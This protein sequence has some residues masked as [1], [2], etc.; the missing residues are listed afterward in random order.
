[1][2]SHCTPPLAR[3]LARQGGVSLIE[4]MI[5]MTIGLVIVV[6]I[7]YAY[8]GAKASFRSQEATSSMQVNARFAF[9]FMGQDIRMAGFTGGTT[10]VTVN[11]PGAWTGLQDIKSFPLRGYEDGAAATDPFPAGLAGRL[12]GTDALTVVSADS[13]A[14][15][16]LNTAVVPN[17]NG[18]TFT[19]SGA[20]APNAA[21]GIYLCADFSQVT[22]FSK[23][24][25]GTTTISTDDDVSTVSPTLCTTGVCR[26]CP[27]MGATY[28]IRNNDANQPSL[29]RLSLQA[30]GTS[31]AQELIQG[32]SDLELVYGV[33]TDNP[34]D[35]TVNAYWTADQVTNATDGSL[36]MP[37]GS[38]SDNWKRVLS[39]RVRLTLT[40]LTTEKVSTS[41][42]QL[43]KTF[44]VNFAVRN[45]L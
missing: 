13:E 27:L 30:D 41:G 23:K 26:I 2:K 33:D 32:A 42:N 39:V 11:Q 35:N 17:P 44:T 22:A 40:S 3:T 6:T 7:G 5:A 25:T 10:D 29:Y 45:R 18:A 43:T 1:M 31:A 4:L 28:F 9:E 12:A 36:S 16:L 37:A 21:G 24:A 15:Y 14:E 19:L 34:A 8:L 38:A 20:V